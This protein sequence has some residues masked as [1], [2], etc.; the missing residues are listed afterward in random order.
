VAE[1]IAPTVTKEIDNFRVDLIG[2]GP[3][4]GV[5]PVLDGQLDILDQGG[6]PLP[7]R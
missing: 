2:V 4:D 7:V 5:R 3:G 6:Q 1:E